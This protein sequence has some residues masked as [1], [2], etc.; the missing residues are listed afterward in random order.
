MAT[1]AM[2]PAAVTLRRARAADAEAFARMMADPQVYGGLMQMPYPDAEAWRARLVEGAAPG[3]QD[4]HLVA[5]AEGQ[6]VGSAGLHPAGPMARRRH[7][8][9][10]GISVAREWQG[11]G[12]GSALMAGLCDYADN[13]LGILRIELTVFVDNPRAIALYERFGFEHEG[14]HRGFALR[15]GVYADAHFMARLHPSPPRVGGA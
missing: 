13:W 14:T 3:K 10:L 6:V 8:M 2:T 4:L 7:V 11:R 12:V 1:E 15:D 9:H 5:E